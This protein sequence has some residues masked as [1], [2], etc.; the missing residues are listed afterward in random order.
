MLVAVLAHDARDAGQ[1]GA[2][3]G[4]EQVVLYLV[5][6]SAVDVG[7]HAVS[8]AGLGHDIASGQYLAGEE[9]DAGVLGNHRHA[10]VVRG[11]GGTHVDA[12]DCQLHAEE[13]ESHAHWQEVEHDR[14]VDGDA[15]CNAGHL[16][17]AV[18]DPA[19]LEQVLDR[20]H[21]QIQALKGEQREEQVALAVGDPLEQAALALG[22]LG[23]EGD[24]VPLDVRILAHG[25]GGGVVL[26][27]LVHPP[28]V[29]DAHDDIG[30][31]LAQ[32]VIALVRSQDLAVCR[33]VRQERELG[34][35][36]A[37]GCGHQQ[38]E[39]AVAQEDE[40]GNGTG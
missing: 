13:G 11:E 5:V 3:H 31:E 24:G 21:M 40:T 39:P 22:V 16:A 35:Q 4:R 36:Q 27:V 33:L 29:A 26:V 28:L 38:L 32:L 20:M 14:Q 15:Q 8:P 9:V 37:Q 18:L 17:L 25:I 1:V 7:E 34:E 2:R 30:Q 19:G 10:L 12:E 23:L 6:Q